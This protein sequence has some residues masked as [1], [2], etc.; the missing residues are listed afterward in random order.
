ML[1]VKQG[2]SEYQLLSILV[3]VNEGIMLIAHYMIYSRIRLNRTPDNLNNSFI[4][5]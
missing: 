3:C 4:W 1:N 5:E 2:S